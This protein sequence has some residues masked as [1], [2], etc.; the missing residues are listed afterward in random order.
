[1]TSIRDIFKLLA[2]DKGPDI[3]HFSKVSASLLNGPTNITE[4]KKNVGEFVL[5]A[6][7]K[8]HHHHVII[9]GWMRPWVMVQRW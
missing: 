1:M 3:D 5:K 9:N 7:T 6:Q 4:N 2:L 8:E